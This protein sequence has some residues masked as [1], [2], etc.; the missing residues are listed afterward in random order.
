MF[1]FNRL[2]IWARLVLIAVLLIA[3]Y[4]ATTLNHVIATTY[5]VAPG[6]VPY[7]IAGAILVLG[8]AGSLIWHGLAL[9]AEA[10]A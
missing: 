4:A 5:G 7:V 10:R 6:L 3:V 2:P 1:K 8:L 9:R